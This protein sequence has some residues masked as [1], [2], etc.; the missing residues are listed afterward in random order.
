M[1]IKSNCTVRCWGTKALKQTALDGHKRKVDETE[2]E[3]KKKKAP[4]AELEVRLMLTLAVGTPLAAASP[5]TPMAGQACAPA[6]KARR[7]HSENLHSNWSLGI[8]EIEMNAPRV[9][10]GNC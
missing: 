9:A 4:T 5:M 10:G 2:P 8:V 1:N 7:P 6:F 3:K